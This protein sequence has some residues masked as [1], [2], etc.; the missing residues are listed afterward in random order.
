MN[1]FKVIGLTMIIA[2]LLYVIIQFLLAMLG[3][4]DTGVIVICFVIAYYLAK[5]L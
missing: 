3:A 2:L 1:P 5:D 4:I